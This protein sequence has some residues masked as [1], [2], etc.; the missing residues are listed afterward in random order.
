MP[1]IEIYKCDKC[2]KEKKDGQGEMKYVSIVVSKADAKSSYNIKFDIINR[3]LWC[4]DCL[5]KYQM[6][7][8]C[9]KLDAILAEDKNKKELSFAE[10]IDELIRDLVVEHLENQ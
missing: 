7:E 2:A 1:K 10:Q 8:K 4:E 5:D 3:Q 9:R 6:M